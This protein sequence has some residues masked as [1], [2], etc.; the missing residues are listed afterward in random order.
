MKI[1][2][3]CQLAAFIAAL[4]FN[5]AANA[6]SDDKP[7]EYCKK[8]KFTDLSFKTYTEA[9]KAEVAG[10]AALTFRLSI[11]AEPK[12][13]VVSAKKEILATTIQTNSSFHEVSFTLPA[14]LS[15]GFVRLNA[16]VKSI[17]AKPDSKC[18]ES[19][20]WLIKVAD[21]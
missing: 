17:T 21:K 19:V 9:E 8:P 14:S 5:V 6:Y 20:G 2:T 3:K 11:D 15:G 1:I 13:L 10:G 18:E 7:G 16:H 4:I 12:S